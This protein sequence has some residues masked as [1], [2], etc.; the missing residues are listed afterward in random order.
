MNINIEVIY[1]HVYVFQLFFNADNG[2]T[3]LFA[4][5]SMLFL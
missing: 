5:C 4:E 3:L 1:I 2:N